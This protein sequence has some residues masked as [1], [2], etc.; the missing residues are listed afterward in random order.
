[1]TTK[2]LQKG[3]DI[4][5]RNSER[6]TALDIA[7]D[8]GDMSL[9]NVLESAIDLARASPTMK[10]EPVGQSS[11]REAGYIPRYLAYL[12]SK[13]EEFGKKGSPEIDIDPGE[14]RQQIFLL[15]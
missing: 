2:L 8:G 4:F 1:M 7:K 13:F 10:S 6:L 9:S 11:A 15:V 12:R 3:F 14:C 5:T